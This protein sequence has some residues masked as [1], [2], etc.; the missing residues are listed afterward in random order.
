MLRLHSAPSAP[1]APTARALMP[2]SRMRG[3][4]LLA[5]VLTLMRGRA[6]DASTDAV[7]G[8]ENAPDLLL[9]Q[10]EGAWEQLLKGSRGGR[11]ASRQKIPT[12]R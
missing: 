8:R 11:S 10:P 7:I 6:E 1:P 2:I 12:S 4:S 5:R 3:Q 9:G